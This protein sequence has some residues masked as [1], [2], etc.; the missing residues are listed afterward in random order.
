RRAGRRRT[1]ATAAADRRKVPALTR[2]AVHGE[3]ST[4]KSAPNA[5]P[6]TI[7]TFATVWINALAAA[8]SDSSTIEG[9]IAATAGTYAHPA[10]VD[11]KARTSAPRGGPLRT[12]RTPRAPM[13]AARI[14]SEPIITRR[15]S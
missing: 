3:P 5:G 1:E 11:R 12:A 8:S 7:A 2:K 13:R 14:K 6:A 9:V 15:K 4:S 10:D